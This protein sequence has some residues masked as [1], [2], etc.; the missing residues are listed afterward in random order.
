MYR[1]TGN[2]EKT[3]KE[4]EWALD[5]SLFNAATTKLSF[6]PDIDLFA[7]RL[8]YQ[9]RPFVSY[10]PDPEAFAINAFHLLWES[11]TFY[12]FPPVSVISRVLQKITEERA[13]GL[14]VVP[15][16]PTQTWW[17]FL[18]NMIIDFR[19][20]LS[21]GADTI[22]LPAHPQTIHPLH[23]SLEL[24][25]CH[26]SGNC[27]LVEEFQRKLQVLSCSPGGK[28]RRSSTGHTFR[29]GN[30]SAIQGM[31]IPFQRLQQMAWISYISSTAQDC[32]SVLST[33]QGVLYQPLFSFPVV[34][35]FELTLWLPVFS[36][37][38]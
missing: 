37:V 21:R 20:V 24:L 14:L 23:T 34:L 17:P 16:W 33:Q 19:L 26:L 30:V 25:V 10:K 11:Y 31:S 1:L 18:M 22:N 15:N 36:R 13:T 5:R 9:I 35:H 29:D 27:L 6:T 38:S 3:R 8:N 2:H 12:A 4:I 7:S 32:H 28:A